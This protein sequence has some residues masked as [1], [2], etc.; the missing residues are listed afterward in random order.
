MFYPLK[1]MQPPVLLQRYFIELLSDFIYSVLK[2]TQ[3]ELGRHNRVS[4]R[5]QGKGRV[6]GM[7]SSL[8][9]LAVF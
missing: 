6:L 7:D 3:F 5:Q 1:I 9:G 4:V 8:R 2:V